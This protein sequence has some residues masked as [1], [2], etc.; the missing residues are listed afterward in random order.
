MTAYEPISGSILATLMTAALV[1]AGTRIAVKMMG[2]LRSCGNFKSISP[3]AGTS[4]ITLT[5]R[6]HKRARCDARHDRCGHFCRR[7]FGV[8]F[9]G[10]R[11]GELSNHSP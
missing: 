10:G 6:L 8:M 4:F 1:L 7:Q 3:D 11:G 5:L 9:G 2:D